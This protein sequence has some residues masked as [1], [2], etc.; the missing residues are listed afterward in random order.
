MVIA[1]IFLTHFLFAV[2]IFITKWK[3]ESAGSAFL[4]LIFIIL[5][6][7]IGWSV[8]AMFAKLIFEQEGFGKHFDRDTIGL[9]VLTIIEYFFYRIYY[10]KDNN[11]TAAGKEIQ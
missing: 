4:N 5:L 2:Y 9:S 3:K 8:L 10:F 6:F 11:S 7:S 1:V